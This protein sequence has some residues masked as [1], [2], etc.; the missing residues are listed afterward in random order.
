[1]ADWNKINDFAS[2]NKEYKS[3]KHFL[4]LLFSQEKNPNFIP[5]LKVYLQ[6]LNSFEKEENI[7]NVNL[8]RMK[9]LTKIVEQVQVAQKSV[10]EYAMN[11]QIVNYLMHGLKVCDEETIVKMSKKCE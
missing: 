10:F 3:Y 5:H 7:G 2:F 1:M 6:E 9:A 11:Q 4:K 8:K